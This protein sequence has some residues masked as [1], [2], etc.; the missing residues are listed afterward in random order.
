[1]Y[2]KTLSRC[3]VRQRGSARSRVDRTRELNRGRVCA[4][5]TVRAPKANAIAER[6]VRT[7]RA[8]CLDWLLIMN[9]RHLERVLRVFA[10]HY[11]T[12]GRT[13]H[14]TSH[15]QIRSRPGSAFCVHLPFASSV[16]T[17]SADSSTNTASPHET[18]FAHPTR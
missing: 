8:E 9:R 3:G 7:V 16:A 17:A 13:A 18:D 14:W 6:F 5:H 11:N 10:D 15:R 12:Q 4:P 1:M 2:Q